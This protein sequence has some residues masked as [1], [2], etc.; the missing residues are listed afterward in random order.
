MT[1]QLPPE[2]EYSWIGSSSAPLVQEQPETE[3]EQQIRRARLMSAQ[4]LERARVLVPAL[5]G[6]K[7]LQTILYTQ[8]QRS[9]LGQVESDRALA[10][11]ARQWDLY[12][13]S[14]WP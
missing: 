6:G 13:A 9:M 4:T 10:E 14:R 2:C 1:E 5:P 7:R 11:A 3:A 12:A 8:L